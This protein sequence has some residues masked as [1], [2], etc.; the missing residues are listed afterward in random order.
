M[1]GGKRGRLRAAV[2]GAAAIL[3]GTPCVQAQAADLQTYGRLP[4]LT[5][6][7]LSPDGH[8]LAFLGVEGPDQAVTRQS[9]LRRIFPRS[10]ERVQSH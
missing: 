5:D 8:R 10:K 1:D 9:W 3:A 7:R 6:V 2:C 4:D